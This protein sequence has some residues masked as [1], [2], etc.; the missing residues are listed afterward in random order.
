[1]P[2]D[3]VTEVLA[4]V[5]V[6]EHL[7]LGGCLEGT[8]IPEALAH[9]SG[10]SRLQ[11]LSLAYSQPHT[12]GLEVLANAKA[13]LRMFNLTHAVVG[14]R[15]VRVLARFPHLAL[16]N[17]S[18]DPISADALAKFESTSLVGLSLERTTLQLPLNL[19]GLSSL[20][21]LNLPSGTAPG[22]EPFDW[23]AYRPAG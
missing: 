7:D 20:R 9:W 12:R 11:S 17:L 1:V 4:H 21:F 3:T 18:E 14:P 23:P 5:P 10:V 19:S 16:L 13:P 8:A 6:L 15:G 2:V 22:F